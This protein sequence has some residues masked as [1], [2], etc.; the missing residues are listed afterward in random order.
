MEL[1]FQE[2]HDKKSLELLSNQ[3]S[4]ISKF[5]DVKA[6][7]KDELI[8]SAVVTI[9]EI[10]DRTWIDKEDTSLAE[11][12]FPLVGS[13]FFDKD[14]SPENIG[15]D[16]YWMEYWMGKT[17]I[18][19][20]IER[21]SCITVLSKLKTIK[22]KYNPVINVTAG[23]FDGEEFILEVINRNRLKEIR[24]ILHKKE[25]EIGNK[26]GENHRIKTEYLIYKNSLGD[27]FYN[28]KKMEFLDK[29]TN[30]FYVFDI[31]FSY[32]DQD[33]FTSYEKID[34]ELIKRS[35]P[36]VKDNEVAAKRIQNAISNKNQGFFRTVK[37]N[38]T[39]ML[40][41]TPDGSKLISIKRGRGLILNNPKIL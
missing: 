19:N 18:R 40:N 1:S 15:L 17:V 27:Y 32:C 21:E 37:I 41:K 36:E 5:F 9:D 24:R 31:I 10:L 34:T 35:L 29:N 39:R 30:Y 4:K 13:L 3:G 22:I 14:R 6:D 38:G 7:I 25:E 11:C 2:K 8:G 16:D 23:I 28:G 12:N 20:I 26:K 33:G